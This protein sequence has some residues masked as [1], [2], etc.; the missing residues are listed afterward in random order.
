MKVR[1]RRH[2]SIE[3][4][5]FGEEYIGRFLN[6]ITRK[7][8]KN[9]IFRFKN[10]LIFG[11]NRCWWRMF[12]TKCVG[13]NFGTL[14]TDLVCWWTIYTKKHQHNEKVSSIFF[15]VIN[16]FFTIIKSPTSLWPFFAIHWEIYPCT[17]RI[18]LGIAY[19]RYLF[20]ILC[21][22]STGF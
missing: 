16:V 2:D 13:D 10:L 7:I 15:P 1:K 5:R 4:L 11:L 9:V 6:E 17:L 20:K 8:R 22:R 19:S 12:E 3:I 21:I 18:S 14:I